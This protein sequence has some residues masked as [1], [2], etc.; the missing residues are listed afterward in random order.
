M[1]IITIILLI[2]AIP[3]LIYLMAQYYD[4]P[5]TILLAAWIAVVTHKVING[6]W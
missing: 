6:E 4:W 3:A 2:I 1:R 5:I